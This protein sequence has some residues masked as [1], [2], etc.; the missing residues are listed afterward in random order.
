MNS[1]PSVTRAVFARWSSAGCPLQMSP[2]KHG[3]SLPKT[4]A[5]DLL[6]AQYV[7]EVEPGEMVRIS[8]FASNP[9]A[10]RRKSRNNIV[11]SNTFIFPARTALFLAAQ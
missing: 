2:G 4:C 5:F 9:F 3:W 1:M 6:N 8:N 10:L 11:S 7:R